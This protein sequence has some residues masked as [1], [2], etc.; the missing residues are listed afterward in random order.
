MTYKPRWL[1]GKKAKQR[2]KYSNTKSVK[3]WRRNDHN[4]EMACT[5]K[6]NGHEGHVYVFYIGEDLYKI[7]RTFD[8]QKRLHSLRAGNPSIRCVWSA[9]SRDSYELEKLIHVSM[10]KHHVDREFFRLPENAV[11][12]INSIACNFNARFE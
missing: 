9:W 12:T 1:K 3:Q 5:E 7:G 10:K 6:K 2:V 11:K 8:V 4:F